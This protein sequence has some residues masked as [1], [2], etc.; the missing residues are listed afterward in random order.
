[1]FHLARLLSWGRRTRTFWILKNSREV[2]DADSLQCFTFIIFLAICFHQRV[3]WHWVAIGIFAS[4]AAMHVANSGTSSSMVQNA[5]LLEPLK[6]FSIFGK[7]SWKRVNE[8]CRTPGHR[9]FLGR[10]PQWLWKRWLFYNRI[11]LRCSHYLGHSIYI[12]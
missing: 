7:A 6:V 8:R 3:G 5:P 9:G 4:P 11:Q 2:F 1:M 10:Y 12:I